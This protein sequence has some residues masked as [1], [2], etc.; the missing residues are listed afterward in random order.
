M[1][2]SRPTDVA[3]GLA[4]PVADRVRV[5]ATL[6]FEL[7]QRSPTEGYTTNSAVMEVVGLEVETNF[8][9]ELVIG[10]AARSDS[11][12]QDEVM[13]M[14]V[15]VKVT[16]KDSAGRTY[17][18]R[19]ENTIQFPR[20][21]S[22][23]MASLVVHLEIFASEYTAIISEGQLNHE[24]AAAWALCCTP[25][26]VLDLLDGVHYGCASPLFPDRF[27]LVPERRLPG[28]A[29][30]S[31]DMSDDGR[32]PVYDQVF[33]DMFKG[34]AIHTGM[35][36]SNFVTSEV[37]NLRVFCRDNYDSPQKV[38]DYISCLRE[39]VSDF[40]SEH[41]DESAHVCSVFANFDRYEVDVA[42]ASFNQMKAD[43]S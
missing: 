18:T 4:D 3:P 24:Q 23:K 31:G 6:L 17:T 37:N 10:M 16:T 38:L 25:S 36:S 1:P 8:R 26:A 13:S 21:D 41:V 14:T 15:L 11:Q 34:T 2:I 35:D 9:G 33:I 29:L 20:E 32:V 19:V 5:S 7:S 43:Q 42:E 28:Q 39:R 22:Q 12:G 27:P 40:R 30:S